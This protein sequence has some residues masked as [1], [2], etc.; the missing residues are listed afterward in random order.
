M[1]HT[2]GQPIIER[3]ITGL[4]GETKFNSAILTWAH[5][6]KVKLI[7]YYIQHNIYRYANNKNDGHIIKWI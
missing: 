4:K 6:F 3:N 7:F 2:Q 1:Y 5:I